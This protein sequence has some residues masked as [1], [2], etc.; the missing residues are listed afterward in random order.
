MSFAGEQEGGYAVEQQGMMEHE[1]LGGS[2]GKLMQQKGNRKA[3][4]F[5]G[6]QEGNTEDGR[7]EVLVRKVRV[8]REA[9]H[10]YQ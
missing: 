5:Y 9:G 7:R 10:A 1:E 6:E 2:W 4:R 8:S 3:V